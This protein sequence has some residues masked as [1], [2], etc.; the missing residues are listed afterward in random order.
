VTVTWSAASSAPTPT[1]V[2]GNQ[3]P[4]LQRTERAFSL[5]KVL[6]CAP[7]CTVPYSTAPIVLSLHGGN[8]VALTYEVN[9]A[10][11]SVTGKQYRLEVVRLDFFRGGEEADLVLSGPVGSD[12]VDP[13]RLVAQSFRW[14]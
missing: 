1:S 3:V 5:G 4:A 13:W 12:N 10:P 6:P 7:S 14:T 2:K 11:N 8:A 9:S